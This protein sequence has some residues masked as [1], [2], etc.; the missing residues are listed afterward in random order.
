M[1]YAEGD[2]VSCARCNKT[3]TVKLHGGANIAV[4]MPDALRDIAL[5][6]QDCA[7]I[8]CTDCSIDPNRGA[9]PPICPICGQLGGPYLIRK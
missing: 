6:C 7:A 2:T 4:A 8:V 5:R 9:T 3:L 1:E